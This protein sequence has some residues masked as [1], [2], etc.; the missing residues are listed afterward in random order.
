MPATAKLR[1][2]RQ[3]LFGSEDP[4]TLDA[5]LDWITQR[6]NAGE[7]V[8]EPERAWAEKRFRATL[9]AP[10]QPGTRE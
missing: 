4:T 3:R 8:P 10:P 5:K 6:I 9:P 2:F 7:A 1:E